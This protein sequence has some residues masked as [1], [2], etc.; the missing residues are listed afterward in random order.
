MAATAP[1]S[2]E[3]EQAESG[4]VVTLVATVGSLATDWSVRLCLERSVE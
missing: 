1:G 4:S 3:A 2:E